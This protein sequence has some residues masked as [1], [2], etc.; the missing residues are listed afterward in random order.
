MPEQPDSLAQWKEQQANQAIF[1]LKGGDTESEACRLLE[2]S[3][4]NRVITA[5]E[6]R[7]LITAR[8]Q[9]AALGPDY[10]WLAEF[11]NIFEEYQLTIGNPANSREKFA[12]V[13]TATLQANR[14]QQLSFFDRLTG[15]KPAGEQ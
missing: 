14:Q 13:L 9:A 3:P 8:C 7:L 6:A 12:A 2:I 1:R 11:A 4:T 15:K 10:I 5:D